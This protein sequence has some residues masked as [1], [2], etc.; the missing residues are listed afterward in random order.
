MGDHV[1]EGCIRGGPG[2]FFKGSYGLEDGLEV[3][4][5]LR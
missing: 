2:G 4:P 1:P 3:E 5:S